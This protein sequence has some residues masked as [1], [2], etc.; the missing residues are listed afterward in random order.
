MPG[1]F[2]EQ[3][4]AR[5]QADEDLFSEA[6][7]TITEAVTGRHLFIGAE[8][9][10][11]AIAEIASV[12]NVPES[13]IRK[14][15]ELENVSLEEKLENIF[16]SCGIMRRRVNLTEGW[17]KDAS[18]VYLATTKEGSYVALRPD[19][20]GY[21]YKDYRTGKKIR[22]NSKTQ[23]E[24]NSEAIC[25]YRPLPVKKL[26]VNDLTRF[27]MKNISL[28]DL[29]YVIVITLLVILVSMTAPFLT[30]II[31]S[32]AIYAG[33]TSGIIS[34]FV[35]MACAG[36]SG[37]LLTISKMLI[38]SRIM[39]KTDGLVNSA[40]MMRLI[41]LPAEFFRRYSS[42]ELA[43]RV[44]GAGA[45]CTMRARVLLS[46]ILTAIMSL[47]YLIQIFSFAPVLVIPALALMAILSFLTV[48][49]TAGHSKLLRLRTKL[50]AEEYGMLYALITGIQK[51]RLSGSE[52]RAFSKWAELYS[53]DAKLEYNPPLFLKLI[54]VIQPAVM[55]IGTF[56]LYYSA[57]KH[58]VSPEDYMAF[59]ASYGL[60]SGAFSALCGATLSMAAIGP[61]AEMIRPV[62]EELPEIS[63]GRKPSKIRGGIEVSNL[64]FKY[65]AN[66]PVILDKIS[67]KVKPGEYVAVV[68][69]SGSGKSTLMRLLLGF[70]NPEGGVIYYDGNDIKTLNLK[71]LRK[72]IG[73]VMQNSKLFT[74]SIYSN[75][76]ISAPHLTEA[77]AWEAAEMAGIA[78][79]IRKMP[80]KMNTLISEGAGTIS[81][82]Q[83]QRIIIARAI[84]PRPKILLFD[85]ATSALDNI[86]QRIVI[87]SLDKLKCTKIVIAH[88]LSTV[89]NC[90]RILVIDGGKIAEHGSYD[91][92]MR[93]KGLFASLV[94]RQQSEKEEV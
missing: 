76:V 62:L 47:T 10:K 13:L 6:L 20:L 54:N 1:W 75:I 59:T 48:M 72:N 87:E 79:D 34:L 90:G 58:S 44:S 69:K 27:A 14:Q 12:F 25:F 26:S 63:Q 23:K 86:T 35:F 41:N 51:I 19:Y 70:E 89:K 49:Q 57:N 74:G 65:G 2:D 93:N 91:E 3:L 73:C 18:G 50:H 24:L 80:M 85:E 33:N 40:V 67:F 88:R 94:E 5:M 45:F 38:I 16:G 82:G 52:R 4:R 60:M 7:S 55:L 66:S 15:D 64:T 29:L 83:R 61:V 71:A 8:S 37:T 56:I 28:Y 78:D 53:K 84:A 17:Y 43:Q 9:A 32:H 77:E 68:G 36:I 92:L 39:I 31:Y 46:V 30:K 42:G 21:S 11:G 81:G 22:V